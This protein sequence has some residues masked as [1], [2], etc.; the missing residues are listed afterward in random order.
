MYG[1]RIAEL[2]KSSGIN[3]QVIPVNLKK[4]EETLKSGANDIGGVI[5]VHCETSTGKINPIH[6]I[7]EM[8][9]QSKPGRFFCIAYFGEFLKPDLGV[10]FSYR[11]CFRL[12]I[13][14]YRILG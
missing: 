2:S 10:F 5:V 11:N 3:V 7:G 12:D 6:E 9:K 1:R 14:S 4:L 8:V 13:L